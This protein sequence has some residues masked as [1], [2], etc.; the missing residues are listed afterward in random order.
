M[1]TPY[2]VRVSQ[3]VPYLWAVI[4]TVALG[5]IFWFVM[6]SIIRADRHERTGME[7][8]EAKIY[9]EERARAGLPPA[10]PS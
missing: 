2:P 9:A 5:L 6:W 4:P 3:L 1:S 8:L 7:R 10:P